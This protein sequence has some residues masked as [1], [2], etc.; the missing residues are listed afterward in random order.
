VQTKEAEIVRRLLSRIILPTDVKRRNHML[1][2]T[3]MINAEGGVIV[4]PTPG[5]N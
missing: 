1:L 2:R 4:E 3:D 5:K